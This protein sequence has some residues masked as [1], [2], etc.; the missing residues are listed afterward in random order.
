MILLRS[1]HLLLLALPLLAASSLRAAASDEIDDPVAALCDGREAAL[2]EGGVVHLEQE[3]T[4]G[5]GVALRACGLIDAPPEQVWPVLRD[6]GDY[7][8]FLPGVERSEL[9]S[10]DGD[11]AVC[12]TFIDLPFP[13]S[14]LHSVTR[15][16]ERALYGGFERSWTLIRG[17]Y[18]RNDGSWRLLRWGSEQDQTLAVY[19]LD[20]DPDTIVPDF[21]LRRAQASTV[22][23]VF[24]AI[25]ERVA[26]RSAESDRTRQGARGISRRLEA[27]LDGVAWCCTARLGAEAPSAALN[28]SVPPRHRARSRS[29]RGSSSR[30][31]R[32]P[33]WD[34]PARA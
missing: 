22:P 29:G 11:V 33:R 13:L 30:R 5:R 25:R 17:S 14:G 20:M 16:R 18:R 10:R 4:G 12:D 6:C 28:P 31:R 26:S 3:P 32:A 9:S 2:R 8:E 19:E 24:D 34:A 27:S 21:L 1:A 15:V 23:R 7:Q